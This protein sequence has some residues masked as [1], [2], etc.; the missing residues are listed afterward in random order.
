M[1]KYAYDELYFDAFCSTSMGNV[2]LGTVSV[3]VSVV[4]SNG[5]GGLE[6]SPVPREHFVYRY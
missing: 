1:G 4:I 6:S 2:G 3:T 5:N